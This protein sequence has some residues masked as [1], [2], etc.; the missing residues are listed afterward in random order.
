MQKSSKGIK[1]FADKLTAVAAADA[2]Q[3]D[4]DGMVSVD[5]A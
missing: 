5:A 3:P 1:V 2:D 4:E